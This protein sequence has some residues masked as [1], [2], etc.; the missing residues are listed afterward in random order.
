[1]LMVVSPAKKLD[2]EISAPFDTFSKPLFLDKTATLIK[3]LRLCSP[4]EISNLMKLS[5]KLTDLNVERYKNFKTGFKEDLGKQAIYAFRG[6][7][8]VGFDADTMTKKDVTFAQKHLRILSGLYGL[9]SPMDLI[10]PYRL[11]MG[12]RFS[13]QGHKNLYEYWGNTLTQEMN[14][15]LKK[16]KTI[17]NLASKEYFQAILPQK[18]EGN[19][20]NIHFKEKKGDDYKVVG[21]MAKRARGMMARY[22]VDNQLKDL[23]DLKSFNIGDY[24]FNSKQSDDHNFVFLR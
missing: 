19:I 15:L 5:D 10:Q 24:K 1:M 16:E 3:G 4:G 17:V 21:F 12:T 20:L 23:E 2:F 8:Y 13:C 11:E 22:I 14:Q 18:L 9:L 6:D 7:T